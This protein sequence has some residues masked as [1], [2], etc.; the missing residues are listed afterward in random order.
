MVRRWA[1]VSEYHLNP[2][3]QVVEG[4]VQSLVRSVM[5]RGFPYCPCRDLTGDPERDRPNMCPCVHHHQEIQADGYCKCVLFVGEG[6]DPK[7]AY[8]PRDGEQKM[9]TARSIRK[10]WVTMYSTS[11]CGD[12]HRAKAHLQRLGVAYDEID[13]DGNAEA[14]KQVETW[15][16]GFRSVPTI[17]ARIVSTE[18]LTSELQSLLLAPRVTV[19]SCKAYIT[20]WCS[21]SRRTMAW[22][23]ERHIAFDVI[24]IE[25]D[26]AAA[27]QVEEWNLGMRSVP[28][29]DMAL[30]ITEP[31]NDELSRFL[32][33][34]VT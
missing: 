31:T 12:C 17:I 3:P 5:A 20:R 7:E 27:T 29:L 8:A 34:A 9:A 28:T 13:I 26:R 14:A 4:I 30:R 23:K 19:M 22:L 11:W 25:A 1:A 18:A 21:H 32:G 16:N 2:D 15:N 6:F 24:D 33:L 10:R